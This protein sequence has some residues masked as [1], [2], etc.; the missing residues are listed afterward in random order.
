MAAGRQRL[1]TRVRG[2]RRMSEAAPK[3]W[4]KSASEVKR[5]RQR[6]REIL[7]EGSGGGV[8]LDAV[9]RVLQLQE[10]LNSSGESDGAHAEL[11]ATITR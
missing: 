2:R 6:A 10:L 8:D 9:R 5:E 4:R 3:P 7:G 1:A 11:Q